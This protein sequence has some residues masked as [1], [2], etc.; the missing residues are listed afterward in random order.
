MVRTSKGV[1]KVVDIQ[2]MTQL[3]L[4]QDETGE[5]TAFGVDEVE[6]ITDTNRDKNRVGNEE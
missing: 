1:G 6:I 2:I 5:T 4:V 3:V